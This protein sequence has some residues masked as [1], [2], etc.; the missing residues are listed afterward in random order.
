MEHGEV[1]LRGWEVNCEFFG[2]LHGH[3]RGS[4]I[5]D[6]FLLVTRDANTFCHNSCTIQTDWFNSSRESGH[7]TIY[8]DTTLL[9]LGHRGNGKDSFGNEFNNLDDTPICSETNTNVSDILI[10]E[11]GPLFFKLEEE[12]MGVHKLV[13]H[14]LI[15]R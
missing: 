8:S 12:T 11:F 7:Y 14:G 9:V 6:M 1:K 15:L 4:Y 3:R 2:F 10:A 5:D 13:H